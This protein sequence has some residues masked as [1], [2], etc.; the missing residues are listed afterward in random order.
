MNTFY[1]IAKK[2]D[3]TL[4][5]L[6]ISHIDVMSNGAWRWDLEVRVSHCKEVNKLRV[7][8]NSH[9]AIAFGYPLCNVGT[10]AHESTKGIIFIMHVLTE[11][12]RSN[13]HD[14]NM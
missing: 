8:D 2:L 12:Q 1:V 7:G 14:E 3:Y 9:G 6:L 11:T 13:V 4:T 5:A 10:D